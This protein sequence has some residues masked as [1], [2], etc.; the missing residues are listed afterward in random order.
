VSHTTNDDIGRR[1]ADVETGL[2]ALTVEVDAMKQDRAW[3]RATMLRVLESVD[4]VRHGITI[5][6][7]RSEPMEADVRSLRSEVQGLS[8]LLQERPCVVGVACPHSEDM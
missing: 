4:G 1:L 2:A 6:S 5:L 7:Q 3:L 8:K